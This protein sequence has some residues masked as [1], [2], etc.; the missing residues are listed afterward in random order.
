MA[1]HLG[2]NSGS[3]GGEALPIT[4]APDGAAWTGPG[5]WRPLAPSRS[6]SGF[7]AGRPPLRAE[8]SGGCVSG[9]PEVRCANFASAPAASAAP[10]HKS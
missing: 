6:A 10:G 4:K 7:P 3:G 2:F 8:A 9:S 1:F 5:P